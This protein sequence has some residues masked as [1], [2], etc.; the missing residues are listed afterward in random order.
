V[1]GKAFS[2]YIMRETF[3]DWTVDYRKTEVGAAMSSQVAARFSTSFDAAGATG[4]VLLGWIYGRLLDR[5]G[6][7][8]GFHVLAYVTLASAILCLGLKSR[9]TTQPSYAP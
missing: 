2:L 3:N 5:G 6:Y 9:R 8:L 7:H 1:C 4:I